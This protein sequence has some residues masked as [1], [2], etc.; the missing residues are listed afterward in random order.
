MLCQAGTD[1]PPAAPPPGKP[2]DALVRAACGPARL[3]PSP[4]D[5][6]KYGD[7]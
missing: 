6:L 7:M 3:W 2:R 4:L 1:G 5:W